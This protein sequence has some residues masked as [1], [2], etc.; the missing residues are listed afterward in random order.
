MA[1]EQVSPPLPLTPLDRS[2]ALVTVGGLLLNALELSLAGLALTLVAAAGYGL[3]RNRIEN[4]RCFDLGSLPEHPQVNVKRFA[5]I[6]QWLGSRQL[7]DGLLG[8]LS[9]P[10]IRR[11]EPCARRYLHG[12]LWP[13]L[14]LR[15]NEKISALIWLHR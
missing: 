12:T 10:E 4:L 1:E 8:D 7:F 9:D 3:T 11:S 14:W 15:L 2:V 13:A 6:C 5:L